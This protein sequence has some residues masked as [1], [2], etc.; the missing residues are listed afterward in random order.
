MGGVRV[1]INVELRLG[2]ILPCSRIAPPMMTS[3]LTASAK[4]GSLRMAMAI[5]VIGPMGKMLISPGS[6]RTRSIRIIHRMLP[7]RFDPGLGQLRVSQPG[8][9]H[10]RGPRRAVVGRA[11]TTLPRATG[12]WLACASS[13]T[14]SALRVAFSRV[15]FPCVVVNASSWI[16]GEA[17]RQQKRK[18]VVHAGVGI[19]N[20]LFG[21]HVFLS[22]RS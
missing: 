10:G 8:F 11:G 17:E 2:V 3:S 13:S 18:G 19:D 4:C 9:R 22:Q 1:H 5:F 12:M 7:D 21:G 20:D 6:A 14:E 16:S 15:T